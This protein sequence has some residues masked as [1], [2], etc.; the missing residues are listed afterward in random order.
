M[1]YIQVDMKHAK[2]EGESEKHTSLTN[3][4][5]DLKDIHNIANRWITLWHIKDS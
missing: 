2:K 1:I 3:Q 4:E 5:I